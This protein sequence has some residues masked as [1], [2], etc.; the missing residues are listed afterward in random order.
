MGG[1]GGFWGDGAGDQA[2]G[3]GV[4]GIPE[5]GFRGRGGSEGSWGSL[6]VS[7]FNVMISKRMVVQGRL[8]CFRIMCL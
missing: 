2:G 1:G 7:E 6:M 4:K 5:R 3:K 8:K